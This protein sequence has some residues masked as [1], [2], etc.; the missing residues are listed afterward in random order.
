MEGID[1]DGVVGHTVE[2]VQRLTPKTRHP[3]PLER[4]PDAV[5]VGREHPDVAPADVA[6]A[7][8]APH[9]V[10]SR[11]AQACSRIADVNAVRRPVR[12]TVRYASSVSIPRPFN[13]AV[14][15][16]RR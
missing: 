3:Q 7:R 5:A 8:E 11:N 9:L 2:L 16:S 1:L 6:A 13:T 14:T 10:A 4:V 15:S 12:S